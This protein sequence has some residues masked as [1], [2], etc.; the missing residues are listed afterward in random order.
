MSKILSLLLF[1]VV[2]SNSSILH[3]KK[4]EL[5][6]RE[7]GDT[8]FIIGGIHGNEPGGYFA[9]SILIQH[10][11]I[12]KGTLWVVPNLNFDSDIRDQRGIYKDMNRKF[13][14]IDKND[15]DYQIVKDIKKLILD[16]RVDLV[17]NLHDGHG[18]YRKKWENIIFNPKAWGQAFI[19]DQS[20]IKTPKYDNLGEICKK[21]TSKIN[22]SIFSKK[23]VFGV[24]NTK[25]KFHDEQM[26]LS[27][28]YFAITHDKPALAIETSKNITELKT[29]V[30][31]QLLAIE[32]FM[33]VMGIKYKR[34]FKLNEKN[35]E[36]I[37][38]EYGNMT[39]NGRFKID[40]NQIKPFI[41]FV[42]IK[43]KNNCFVF[44]H[45]LGAVI[46][47]NNIYRTMI[48]N[49]K[50]FEFKPEYFE[51]SKIKPKITFVVDGKDT[52][53]TNLF[54]VNAK[55]S[56]TV[57]CDNDIRVNVIG[58]SKKGKKNESNINISKKDIAKRY[59]I[60]KDKDTYRV[61]F[62][63]KKNRYIKTVLVNFT[64]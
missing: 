23:H 30:Y 26:K 54:A 53:A 20:N 49:K 19:I 34:D 33:N 14:H 29:K 41:N 3:F 24:K 46:K 61:E 10:Y 42:P 43:I 21:I 32:E 22:G 5:N 28:T 55:K 45:P 16:K 2:A 44:S 9:P 12:L 59:S 38:K 50:I 1:L 40:L 64:K 13:A 63:D 51:L 36:K 15:P 57:K 39:I 6:G 25:T 31:Y 4:Y 62:Y 35:I 37:L 11:K 60:Y 47:D 48:G 8:L 58:F 52:D 7:K 56:F 17:L 18:F 27:L